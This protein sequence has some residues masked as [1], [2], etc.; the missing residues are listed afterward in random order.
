MKCSLLT[1]ALPIIFLSACTN[2]TVPPI[3][4]T[5]PETVAVPVAQTQPEIPMFSQNKKPMLIIMPHE[6]EGYELYVFIHKVRTVGYD[7]KTG[8]A[9]EVEMKLHCE[10]SV[11]VFDAP[12]RICD[13]NSGLFVFY[14]KEEAM[15][16]LTK[17]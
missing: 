3:A 6:K 13:V 4:Q 17:Y 7:Q 11:R 15:A 2:T 8:E 14:E 16:L 10:K 1:I 9:R 5:Q 12:E